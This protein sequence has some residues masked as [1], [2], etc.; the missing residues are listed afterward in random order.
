MDRRVLVMNFNPL[1]KD[2]TLIVSL[3][4]PIGQQKLYLPDALFKGESSL[5]TQ[6]LFVQ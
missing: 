3:E 4:L 5:I 6:E 1:I 2:S